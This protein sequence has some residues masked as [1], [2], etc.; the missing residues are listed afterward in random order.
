MAMAGDAF[1]AALR[2]LAETPFRPR[3]WFY[4]GPWGGQF[5]RDHMGL[6]PSPPTSR[7]RSS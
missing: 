7:G 6:N 1:R 5:M 3:P 4:P 2:E